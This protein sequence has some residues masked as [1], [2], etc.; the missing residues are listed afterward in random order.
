MAT[1]TRTSQQSAADDEDLQHLY[2]EVWA[3]FLDEPS[4]AVTRT[5]TNSTAEELESLY[6]SYGG[7]D[8][9]TKQGSRGAFV[10]PATACAWRTTDHCL[11]AELDVGS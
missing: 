9:P 6:G 7:D 11:Y 3:G 5:N 8:A 2:N 4:P 10:S 1:T